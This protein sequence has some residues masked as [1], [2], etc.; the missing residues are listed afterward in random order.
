MGYI[1][2]ILPLFIFLL[3]WV[4]P[5]ISIPSVLGLSFV[6][7]RLFRAGKN[8]TEQL[9]IPW[10]ALIILI[11][12]SVFWPIIGGIVNFFP[13]SADVRIG[14][15]A[16]FLDLIN[17]P[18]PII[19]PENGAAVTYY[20]A[21][22]LVPALLGKMF[23]WTVAQIALI[24]WTSFGIF[25]SITLLLFY[26]R[27]A[28]LHGTL[29]ILGV[30]VFFAG[31]LNFYQLLNIQEKIR[32]IEYAAMHAQLHF[33]YNQAVGIWVLCAL[34]LHEKNYR[35]MGF[36]IFPIALYSPYALIGILPFAAV[37]FFAEYRKE[38]WLEVFSLENILAFLLIIPIL[39]AYLAANGTAAS[40]EPI[41][42]IFKKYKLLPLL[43]AYFI[44]FGCYVIFIFRDYKKN[45][46]FYVML[47]LLVF[48]PFIQYSDD[49]NFSR[50][51]IPALFFL[52][53][54]VMASLLRYRKDLSYGILA[55][56]V[57]VGCAS[58]LELWKTQGEALIKNG[59][60]PFLMVF[61]SYNNKELAEKEHPFHRQYLQWTVPSPKDYV[62][63]RYLAKKKPLL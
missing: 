26:L 7:Y 15:N 40:P 60:A 13:P 33:L 21:H 58:G 52:M 57:I 34:Y 47:A 56:F 35:F 51:A 37:K 36:L 23:G 28:S 30:F 14:R 8:D 62:F 55:A 17:Y 22:W 53:V 49:H 41:Q 44:G 38:A 24:L 12:L 42:L 45:H 3:G 18:W 11:V 19:Y 32:F 31:L 59:P 48:I 54:M 29:L 46:M 20:I 16:M 6:F 1:F 25:V 10:S 2:I 27:P 4:R 50:T 43:F 63:F 39:Y 61:Q 5:L 9:S